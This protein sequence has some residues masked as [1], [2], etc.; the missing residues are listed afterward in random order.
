[1]NKFLILLLFPV[2]MQLKAQNYIFDTSMNYRFSNKN[3]NNIVT[4]AYNSSDSSYFL[5]IFEGKSGKV[6]IL[7]DYNNLLLHKYNV[8]ESIENNKSEMK[9]IYL[10]SLLLNNKDLNIDPKISHEFDFSGENLKLKILK[11]KKK[12]M[13]YDIKLINDESN[14]FS[15]FRLGF[16]HPFEFYNTIDLNQN[17]IVAYASSVNS[18][19]Y[20]ESFEFID[21]KKINLELK[22]V[23]N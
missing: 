6:A 7:T 1:M 10:E 5:K 4:V 18:V 15:L 11:G 20:R 17:V 9:F 16:M 14:K 13:Q 2:F 8:L 22:V 3:L 19:G 23:K 21:F 12:L